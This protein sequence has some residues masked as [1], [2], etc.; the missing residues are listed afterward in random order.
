MLS[1]NVYLLKRASSVRG[2]WTATGSCINRAKVT[3]QILLLLT[4]LNQDNKSVAISVIM[5]DRQLYPHC[6]NNKNGRQEV[7]GHPREIHF[8]MTLCL[9]CFFSAGEK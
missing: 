8:L 6:L 7:K 9:G 4:K 2:P 5:T 1:L 3:P